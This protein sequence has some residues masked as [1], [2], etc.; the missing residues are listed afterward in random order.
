MQKEAHV[1]EVTTTATV[2]ADI[3][4]KDTIIYLTTKEYIDSLSKPIML[5]ND[6]LKNDLTNLLNDKFAEQRIIGRKMP[7]IS[8]LPNAAIASLI[9]AKYPVKCITWTNR[10]DDGNLLAVYQDSGKNKG[11]YVGSDSYFASLICEFKYTTTDKDIREIMNRLAA[12]APLVQTC[13]EQDLIAVNNGIFNY[14]TKQL[15]PFSPDYVFTAKSKVDYV[16]NAVNPMITMPDGGFWDVE[17]WFNS[18]SDDPEIVELLWKVCGAVIRPH[19]RWDKLVCFY[20]QVGMNGKGTLCELMKLLCGDGT[21]ASIPFTGFEKDALA[22]QLLTA[23]AVICDENDTNTYTKSVSRLKALATGDS[24]CIDIKYKAALTFAFS[25]LIV[26]CV[27]NLPKAGDQTDSFYRRFLM[28]PFDK[29]FKGVERKYIKSDYLHRPEVLEY[30]LCKV[31]NMDY[32]ELSEPVACKALLDEYKEYNNPVHQFVQ[33]IFPELV[34]NKIPVAFIYDLYLSWCV[35]NNPS[36]K[37]VGKIS[38]SKT[39]VQI[40]NSLFPYEW[41][42]KEG[43]TRFTKDDNNETEILIYEYNLSRWVSSR[44]KGNDIQKLCECEFREYYKR[45]FVRMNSVVSDE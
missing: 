30:V 19:V 2:L 12:F 39:V 1:T 13:K 21:Y 8:S 34:W 9:L 6:E 14:K 43:T 24:I 27:N 28:I 5:S 36:G 18:I 23:T 4:D 40:V 32:Y 42:Y 3:R 31:L 35:R 37:S 22:A 38:F 25:G 11:I 29:T 45:C 7:D 16:P 33:E 10:R 15:L 26:E 17:S 44:Y 41:T 20:S